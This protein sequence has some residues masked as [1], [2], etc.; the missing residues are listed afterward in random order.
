MGLL[1]AC[2]RPVPPT[3]T[4][5]LASATEPRVP[6]PTVQPTGTPLPS[7][8]TGL[9]EL[10]MQDALTGWAWA[11]KPDNSFSLLHTLDG[12]ATWSD[13]TP[14]NLPIV[15]FGSF[16]LD[17][18]TAWV[19][20]FDSTTNTN[21]LARSTDGGKTWSILNSS[22][23]FANAGLT[24][25][26]QSNGWAETADV[27]AGNAYVQLY[28]T[29]D[30]GTTWNQV[31]I[32]APAPEP[33]LQPGTIHLCNICGDTLYY[34]PQ[35]LVLTS[36]DLATSP[37]GAVRLSIS[38]NLGKTWTAL[39][40]P[41]P[42]HQYAQDLIAPHSPTFFGP[43]DGVL[44]VQIASPDFST[45]TL[46]VYF[47]HDGGATWTPGA[48]VLEGVSAYSLVDFLSLQ[49]AYARCGSSLCATHD[50]SQ[51]W[52]KLPGNLDFDTSGTGTYVFHF[53]FADAMTG[54]AI[55]TDGTSSTLWK[56]MD[57]GMTW[58]KLSPRFAP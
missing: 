9:T 38:K 33:S 53:D 54:W 3:E 57:G 16:F 47:T 23:A 13:V 56:T 30:G 58:T 18:K 43:N 27:G 42:S 6:S 46:A 50:A 34:D 31:Q 24:F 36:G 19:Q 11:S 49:D 1:A 51:T 39:K 4:F 37:G 44:P 25:T 7:P 55:T 52:Q 22:L 10:H 20:L 48:A 12:G 40:L 32:V 2:S 5:T 35:R 14:Q 41:L 28:Q 17:S 45:N 8:V 15:S 21:G 29:S 26:S